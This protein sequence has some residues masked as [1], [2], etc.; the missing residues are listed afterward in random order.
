MAPPLRDVIALDE[1]GFRRHFKGSPVK[2][3]RRRGLLRN[4]AVALGNWADPAAVLAL[5]HALADAEPLI[6][7]H[8]AWALGCIATDDAR[9][10]LAEAQA[11]ETDIWVPEELRLALER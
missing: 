8:A 11:T 6:R 2:R 10:A 9:R 3:A 4:A 1:E 5:T 7:G